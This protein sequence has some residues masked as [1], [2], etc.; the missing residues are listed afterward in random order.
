MY[1]EELNT[2]E[3]EP[4]TGDAKPRTTEAVHRIEETCLAEWTRFVTAKPQGSQRVAVAAEGS[5]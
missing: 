4:R 1:E 5:T 2:D 3:K